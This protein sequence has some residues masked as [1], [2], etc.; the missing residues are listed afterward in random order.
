MNEEDNKLEIYITCKDAPLSECIQVA[1][2]HN[3]GIEIK[4]FC[5]HMVFYSDWHGL[6]D[7]TKKQLKDFNGPCSLHGVYISA[8]YNWDRI[9]IQEIRKDYEKTLVV[10]EE[11]GAKDIIVYS[12]YTPGLTNWKYKDWFNIQV[13]LWGYISQQAEKQ[14]TTVVIENIA[15]ERPDSILNVVQEVNSDYLK[16]CI[17]FG[18]LNLIP[19]NLKLTDWI[20]ELK[21]HLYYI[22]VHNNNGRYDSHSTIDNGTIDYKKVFKKL[23]ELPGLPKIGV[24]AFNLDGVKSSL[25]TLEEITKQ[26]IC[27]V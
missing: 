5:S 17:D 21:N 10:A 1:K 2:T 22:H 11:L 15:D 3:L 20:E 12:T 26:K 6:L 24:E 18:H 16:A 23:F 8:P 19:T 14:E 27:A 13:D 9:S 7:V 25:I 4:T